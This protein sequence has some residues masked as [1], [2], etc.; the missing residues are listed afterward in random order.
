[1]H[2]LYSDVAYS[3]IYNY[4]VMYILNQVFFSL[5]DL[6]FFSFLQGDNQVQF[7]W[8]L[9]DIHELFDLQFSANSLF[10]SHSWVTLIY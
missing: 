3:N 10:S 2:Y 6:N 1:M 4:N 8:E 5:A 9:S 7:M